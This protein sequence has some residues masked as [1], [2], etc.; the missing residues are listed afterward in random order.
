MK[1][2]LFDVIQQIKECFTTKNTLRL[3]HK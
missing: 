2:A 3:S 1:I